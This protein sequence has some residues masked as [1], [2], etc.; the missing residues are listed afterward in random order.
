MGLRAF[1]LLAAGLGQ[2]GAGGIKRPVHR[3]HMNSDGLACPSA[4]WE[5]QAIG[6]KGRRQIQ[7]VDDNVLSSGQTG[8]L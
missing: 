8:T 1:L 5:Y 2:P 4:L 6:R 3:F 7:Q